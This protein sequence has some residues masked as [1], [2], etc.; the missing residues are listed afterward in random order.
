MLILPAIVGAAGLLGGLHWLGPG[1]PDR[2]CSQR[3]SALILSARPAQLPR[4]ETP[5]STG[6][7][8]RPSVPHSCAC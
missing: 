7:R 2:E 5:W 8:I 1:T 6:P 3:L 4:S